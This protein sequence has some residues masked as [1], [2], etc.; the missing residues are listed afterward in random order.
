MIVVSSKRAGERV[1]AS[2][3]R[4]VERKLKLKVND[5][6]SQVILDCFETRRQ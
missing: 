2:I 1:M 5:T 3:K 4:F 6:K